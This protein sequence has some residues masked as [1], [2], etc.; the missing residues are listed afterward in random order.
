MK[1]SLAKVGGFQLKRV[2]AAP[3]NVWSSIVTLIHCR[4]ER[5]SA[6]ATANHL[7]LMC[8][9][10]LVAVICWSIISPSSECFVVLHPS[11]PALERHWVMSVAGASREGVLFPIWDGACHQER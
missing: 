5:G 1:W 6:R 8:T 11:L 4:E 10:D 3:K 2:L 9:T 7:T